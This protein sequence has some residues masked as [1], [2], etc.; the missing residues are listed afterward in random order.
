MYKIEIDWGF[1]S[2]SMQVLTGI[3]RIDQIDM[4]GIDPEKVQGFQVKKEPG[5]LGYKQYPAIFNSCK[6]L[7]DVMVRSYFDGMLLS[8]KSIEWFANGS[9]HNNNVF[10]TMND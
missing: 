7:V 9:R 1:K 6:P 5:V 2:P 4:G 8:E 10:L 3:V